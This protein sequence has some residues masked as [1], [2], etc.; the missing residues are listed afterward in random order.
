MV[1]VP[2][3]VYVAAVVGVTSLLLL[4][5]NSFLLANIGELIHRAI[6]LFYG[7]RYDKIKKDAQETPWFGKENGVCVVTGS[8][9]GMVRIIHTNCILY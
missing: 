1:L 5:R 3:Q 8:N 2:S 9:S 6:H 7:D 4:S